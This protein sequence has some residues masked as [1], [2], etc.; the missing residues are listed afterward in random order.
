MYT[1]ERY[2]NGKR[3]HVEE[4]VEDVEIAPENDENKKESPVTMIMNRHEHFRTKAMKKAKQDRNEPNEDMTYKFICSHDYDVGSLRHNNVQLKTNKLQNGVMVNTYT[5]TKNQTGT[6]KVILFS[7]GNATDLGGTHPIA[8]ALCKATCCTIV[9]Y[10]YSGENHFLFPFM[11]NLLT[12]NASGYGHSLGFPTEKKT[13][14]DVE[15]VYAYCQSLSSN[16]DSVSKSDETNTQSKVILYGQSVGSGPSCWYAAKLSNKGSPPAGLVLH[17]PFTSGIRVLTNEEKVPCFIQCLDIYDNLGRMEKVR[18][19]VFILHG[20][21]DEE[22]DIRHSQM[23]LERVHSRYARDPWWV[24]NRGHNDITE[25][26]SGMT[27]YVTK[28]NNFVNSLD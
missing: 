11:N 12:H 8:V 16:D 15:Q 9:T 26:R 13:Y 21:K 5:P 4:E 23:L 18:C 24:P 28:I 7:H 22:I 17:C 1:I 19:P 6:D 27:E 2:H 25:G 10:D 3:Y 20:L 14:S